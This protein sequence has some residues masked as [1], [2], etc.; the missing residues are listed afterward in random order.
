MYVTTTRPGPGCLTSQ[1]LTAP[2][3]AALIG[4]AAPVVRFAESSRVEE[5]RD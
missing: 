4:H 2:A 5:C 3:A 1:A